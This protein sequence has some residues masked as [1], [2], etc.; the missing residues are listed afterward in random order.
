MQIHY[1][2]LMLHKYSLCRI[3]GRQ[4]GLGGDVSLSSSVCPSNST[5]ALYL[6]I[7]RA[8]K[9]GCSTKELIFT[10][11][12]QLTTN[13]QTANQ[14]IYC[15][16]HNVTFITMNLRTRASSNGTKKFQDSMVNGARVAP[17]SRK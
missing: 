8:S 5:K 4:R 6:S 7:I 14:N 15:S 9:T 16:N 10:P 11:L 13:K 3:C 1:P 2:S 12:L 17:T